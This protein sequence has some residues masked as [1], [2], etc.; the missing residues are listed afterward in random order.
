MSVRQRSEALVV[1][2]S[3]TNPAASLN[4]PVDL[5]GLT[6][7]TALVN[8]LGVIAVHSGRARVGAYAELWKKD[9]R[10][11]RGGARDGARGVG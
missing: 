5:V 8:T 4:S 6:I 10:E 7:V 11:A 2:S 3:P 1:H 9:E